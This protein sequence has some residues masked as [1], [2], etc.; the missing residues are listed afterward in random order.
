LDLVSPLRVG[1]RARDR[2][3][4]QSKERNF[5]A[6]FAHFI[7]LPTVIPNRHPNFLIHLKY[8]LRDKLAA[9]ETFQLI[10]KRLLVFCG[11]M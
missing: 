4:L 8:I 9:P 2:I 6:N 5:Q 11:K 10:L 7:V 1:C 3:S